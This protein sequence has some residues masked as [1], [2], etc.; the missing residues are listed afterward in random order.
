M[1][2]LPDEEKVRFVGYRLFSPAVWFLLLECI[3]QGRI[4]Q[5]NGIQAGVGLL[6]CSGGV[7][8]YLRQYFLLHHYNVCVFMDANCDSDEFKFRYEPSL[9]QS[10]ISQI[11]CSRM[12]FI[13]LAWGHIAT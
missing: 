7:Q 2:K 3:S 11:V 8:G 1:Q 4:S 6:N 12:I 13:A 9:I 10:R 5:Q